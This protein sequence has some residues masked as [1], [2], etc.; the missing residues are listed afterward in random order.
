[1]SAGPLLSPLLILKPNFYAVNTGKQHSRSAGK[2]T[3]N[4]GGLLVKGGGTWQGLCGADS[5]GQG[6]SLIILLTLINLIT[7]VT[8][9][10]IE[11]VLCKVDDREIHQH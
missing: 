6:A 7:F 8:Q 9:M 2:R 1:M 11:G 4:G 10:I 5:S 3:D